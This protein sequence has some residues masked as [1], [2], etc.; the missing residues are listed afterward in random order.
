MKFNKTKC[1]VPHF[2]HD[3][4]NQ[5][6]RFGAGWLEDFVEEADLGVLVDSWLNM[7]KQCA[8]VAK[9]ANGILACIRNRVASRSKAVIISLYS[10]LVRLHL[11][12]VFSFGPLTAIKMSRPWSVFRE[13]Q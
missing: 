13:G 6:Y 10:A 11:D 4:I 2:G 8:Q 7:S 5:C 3:N 12:T 1:Q 9:K